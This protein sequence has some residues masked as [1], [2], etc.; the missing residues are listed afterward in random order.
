MTLLSAKTGLQL[1][2]GWSKQVERWCTE[3]MVQPPMTQDIL[4]E[5]DLRNECGV[6]RVGKVIKQKCTGG[7]KYKNN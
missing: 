7:E 3:N 2:N 6:Q 5:Y 4:L 1:H